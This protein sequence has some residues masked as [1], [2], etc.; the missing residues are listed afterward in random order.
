MGWGANKECRLVGYTTEFAATEK[1]GYKKCVCS[2]L[3]DN[4]PN[5]QQAEYSYNADPEPRACDDSPPGPSPPVPPQPE[6]TPLEELLEM[7][8]TIKMTP[9]FSD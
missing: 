6:K 9:H 4:D 3:D 5:C 8:N 2:Y 7:L 1:D